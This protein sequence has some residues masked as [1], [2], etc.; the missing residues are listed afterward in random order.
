MA[1]DANINRIKFLRSTTSG[2]KP[3]TSLIQEGELALNFADRTIYSRSGNDIIELGFGKGGNVAGD[4]YVPSNTVRSKFVGAIGGSDGGN[5][6]GA[7]L[8]WNKNNGQGRTDFINNRGQG[9][10]GFDFWNG[11]TNANMTLVASIDLNGNFSKNANTATTLQTARTI[12]LSGDANGSISFNGGSDVTINTSVRNINDVTASEATLNSSWRTGVIGVPTNGPF[13]SVYRLG[14]DY[15][16]YGTA[17]GSNFTWG[18]ADT[19]AF[20]NTNYSSPQAWLG[21]GNNNKI[22]WVKQLAFID[23]TVYSAT[24]LQT[25]R[26]IWGQSFDGTGDITGDFA[27]NSNIRL[28]ADNSMIVVGNNQD[29]GL[30]KK[31]GAAGKLVIGA[32]NGFVISKSNQAAINPSDT[33]SD[34]FGV[35]NS[36]NV[37]IIN[38]L[39]YTKSGFN[40]NLSIN[41]SGAYLQLKNSSGGEAAVLRGFNDGNGD[42]LNLKT[43]GANIVGTVTAGAI[44]SIGD[45]SV[46]STLS[47]PNNAWSLNV[48]DDAVIGDRNIANHM[49][50]KGSNNTG[51]IAFFNGN[52]QIASI[53]GNSYTGNSASATKLQTVRTIN[54]TPFDGTANITINDR[55]LGNLNSE[56]GINNAK[57]PGCYVIAGGAPLQMYSYGMLKVYQQNDN[58]EPLTQIFYSHQKN[59]FGSIA[60]RQS[61]DGGTSWSG[62]RAVDDGFVA[63]GFADG[64]TTPPAWNAK[65]GYYKYMRDGYS[66]G[67]IHFGG[68]GS[69]STSA[70]QIRAN[71]NNSGLWWRSSVDSNGFQVD[72]DKIITEQSLPNY[73]FNKIKFDGNW[74]SFWSPNEKANASI[75]DD[76]TFTIYAPNE[77]VSGGVGNTFLVNKL[78]DTTIVGNTNIGKNVE[79]GGTIK[80][81][82]VGDGA[83]AFKKLISAETTTDGGYLAVG[84]DGNDLGYVEIGTVDD[85]NTR[86]YARQR[87]TDNSIVRTVILL[88]ENG[89]SSFPGATY[90]NALIAN[91]LAVNRT[92]G[93]GHGLSLFNGMSGGNGALPQYGVS[94]AKT[95]NFGTY[96]HTDEEW[97]TYFTI[98]GNVPRRGWIFKNNDIGNVF[99]ING[100]G[101]VAAKTG[102]FLPD[103]VNK[104]D[105]TQNNGIYVGNGDAATYDTHNVSIRSWW[106]IGFHDYQNVCRIVF[107]TRTGNI[108]TQGTVSVGNSLTVSG[109]TTTNN[110]NV[111]S[112]LLKSDANHYIDMGKNGSDTVKFAT[113]GGAFNFIDT[114]NGSTGVSIN[115]SDINNTGGT[116]RSNYLTANSDVRANGWVYSNKYV[117]LAGDSVPAEFVGNLTG[118]ANKA[119]SVVMPNE[120]DTI[121]PIA[122]WSGAV[123]KNRAITVVGVDANNVYFD[124]TFGTSLFRNNIAVGS[125]A[126]IAYRDNFHLNPTF[127]A[128]ITSI[129]YNQNNNQNTIR[130]Y[131]N[132]P[133]HGIAAGNMSN[134]ALVAYTYNAVGCSYDGSIAQKVKLNQDYYSYLL[135]LTNYSI[136]KGK[137]NVQISTANDVGNYNATYDITWMADNNPL[138]ASALMIKPDLCNFVISDNNQ[139]S[140]MPSDYV[141]ISI[142]E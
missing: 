69:G 12:T 55:W 10:G 79:V 124:T 6:Q 24:K 30:L 74:N 110:F 28:N 39:S 83:N 9:G 66:E 127:N 43:G 48:G 97:A 20:I 115:K 71:Y 21:G 26:S 8:G 133:N 122:Q 25:P 112:G 87:N 46:L 75:G 84:N 85:P 65:S 37:N 34:I 125:I 129:T 72:W 96:G 142:W 136:P 22:N 140:G 139:D 59:K 128:T 57:T 107:D 95:T 131:A 38:D 40:A 130:V 2:N 35:S 15:A 104:T 54:G 121:K 68:D 63:S 90:A 61:W 78:G 119:K 73:A 109:T 134:L 29:I 50:I 5:A 101:A 49:C 51:G 100:N 58:A 113:Y 70:I 31:Q 64:L 86:I 56:E 105:W 53:Q 18:S 47:L 92:D 13:T 16:N 11:T 132:W 111:N 81:L 123:C 99:S 32:N 7:W 52:T 19:H 44:K 98:S 17:F 82:N 120:F 14:L 36:G 135:K 89:D 1:I 102:Y 33:F 91:Q 141:S 45:I 23:S 114:Q 67:V 93:T 42:Q 62:W 77:K 4:I 88:N 3:T 108:S 116:T 106:G 94:F 27:T 118:T 41:T 126:H 137:G 60:I 76:G 103:A 117:S 80:V 138:C